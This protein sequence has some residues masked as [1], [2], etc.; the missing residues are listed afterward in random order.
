M[1]VV[2]DHIGR[3]WW[4]FAGSYQVVVLH[5][6]HDHEHRATGDLHDRRDVHDE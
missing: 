1:H 3:R 2:D 6:C 4:R 5:R